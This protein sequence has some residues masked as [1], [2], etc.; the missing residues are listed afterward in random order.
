[1]VRSK[2]CGGYRKGAGRPLELVG[3]KVKTVKFEKELLTKIK[4]YG[5]KHSLNFSQ[6]VR[7]L[8]RKARV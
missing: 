8:V 2:K 6:S 3:G 4:Q 5:K 7:A 1:M